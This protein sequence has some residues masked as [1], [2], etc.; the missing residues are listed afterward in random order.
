MTIAIQ[1]LLGSAIFS[2]L[3]LFVVNEGWCKLWEML[4]SR[5]PE[6]ETKQLSF[7]GS[8]PESL[9]ALCSST[10][11][12]SN[13]ERRSILLLKPEERNCK[14]VPLR[15]RRFNI[16]L[17]SRLSIY[18][19]SGSKSKTRRTKSLPIPHSAGSSSSKDPKRQILPEDVLV[20]RLDIG[21]TRF[22]GVTARKLLSP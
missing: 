6:G 7:S 10:E 11:K 18:W 14:C 8:H 15:E 19:I 3:T 2:E 9:Q 17:R 21:A 4:L 20:L 16:P 5:E 12:D 13:S 1:P 22:D